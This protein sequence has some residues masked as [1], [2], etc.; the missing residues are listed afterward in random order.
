MKA[1]HIVE[2]KRLYEVT[3]KS[4]PYNPD[5]PDEE[6]RKTPIPY[7][8]YSDN[9]LLLSPSYRRLAKHGNVLGVMMGMACY[10]LY[11]KLVD[12]AKNKTRDFR[13]WI[14]DENN[15]PLD[16]EHIA[17]I[18]EIKDRTYIKKAFD[19]LVYL[20]KLEYLELPD[21][22]P[23]PADSRNSIQQREFL[24][25]FKNVTETEEE[26]KE[27][28]KRK[29]PPVLAEAAELGDPLAK[30]DTPP[31][32]EHFPQAPPP[33]KDSVKD[34]GDTD[35]DTVSVPT[36]GPGGNKKEV[37]VAKQL[38]LLELTTKIHIRNQSDRTTLY[39]IADQL[40]HR[41]IYE[42]EED[43]FTEALAKLDGCVKI[44]RNPLAMFVSAMKKSPFH[45]IPK[46]TSYIRAAK[47]KYNENNNRP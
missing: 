33:V 44:G 37:A 26:V 12:I 35:T 20:G 28:F 2:W 21:H 41:M 5:K 30:H 32:A 7:I 27:K 36:G 45:Y 1:Y 43:L 46:G 47:D 29:D 15:Y 6:L 9:G 18:L 39:D 38:F 31:P 24:E 34:S 10:G 3:S 42:T 4:S 40:E 25:P 16:P 14:V 8:R 19:L 11:W 23:K 13:G 22:F 17:D